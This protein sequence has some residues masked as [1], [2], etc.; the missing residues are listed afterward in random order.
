MTRRLLPLAAL[1][2]AAALSTA[3]VPAPTGE[4]AEA[5]PPTPVELAQASVVRIR[6][7][8]ACGVAIGT[9]FVIDGQRIVTNRHV[10]A[11]A[12]EL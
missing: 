12:R 1:L 9:G 5:E 11:G 6:N 8:S 10:V 2:L 7:V 4:V 3:C